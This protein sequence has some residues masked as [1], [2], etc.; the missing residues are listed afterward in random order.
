MKSSFLL[1]LFVLFVNYSFGQQNTSYHPLDTNNP[2]NFN[3]TSIEYNGQKI[4]LGPKT[5]FIDGQLSDEEAG[6]Y[7][8]VFNSIQSASE[9]LTDGTE[10]E[11]MILYI[12]P[13]VYWIDNPDDP[14]VRT[15]Q[16]GPVPY[17]MEIDCEWLRFYGLTTNPENV[18][19]ACNRGQTMGSMGNFTMFHFSGDGTSSENL[20]F[21]N[22]CNVDLKFPLKPELN[23]KKRGD[24][25]VQAQLIHCNGDKIVA[26]N[27][28]F[29]SRLN[30][31][32]FVG[33]KRILF[34]QCHLECTDDALCG[35]G[36]YLN[37]TFD[38]YSS[39]PFY[40]TVGTGSVFLNCDIHTFTHGEQYLTKAN[41]QM[42]IIDSRFNGDKTEYIGWRNIPPVD[43]KNYQYNVSLNNKPVFISSHDSAS[44]IDLTHLPLLN[45]YRLDIG[46]SVVYNTYNL[47]KGNDDWD[48]CDIK[49]IVVEAEK[50][51][52]A[53]YSNIPTQLQIVTS[54]KTVETGKDSVTLFTDIFR[55]GDF[56]TED[57]D[58][59]WHVS[60]DQQ[61][62]LKLI[63]SS[64]THSCKLIPTNQNDET[65]NVI[66]YA[67]TE[68]GLE[69]ACPIHV[70]PAILPA[71]AFTDLPILSKP[72]KNSV[73]VSYKLD[74]PY[75]D[76]SLI[77]WYRC[78]DESGKNPIPVAVSR[79]NTP[80]KEY[81][82]SSRD[83]G[84]Y[85]MVSV[86]PK[87]LR[88]EPGEPQT[89]VLQKA[90]TKNDI[91]N[92][93]KTLTTDFKNTAVQN[94]VEIIPG[95][96]TFKP[97]ET[98]KDG[99]TIVADNNKDAWFYGEGKEGNANMQG[100]LQ[101]GRSA[102]LLY[103]P[104][105]P[106]H[107]KM[108]L[109]MTVSPFKTAG[110]GFSVAPLYMDV[111]FKL[112]TKNMTG[113]GLRFIRTTK[114]GNAVDCYFVKYTNGIASQIGKEITTSCF[115]SPVKITLE[116][117]KKKIKAR[118]STTKDYPS[119][120][121]YPDIMPSVDLQIKVEEND[122]GGFGVQY[123]GGSTTMIND[124]KVEWE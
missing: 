57:I 41:G 99:E 122:F 12:A 87:H 55:F 96:W 13:W 76:Q 38:F 66:I 39:K 95:F 69:A 35:T 50:K 53:N 37:C 16:N 80:L 54:H 40:N 24:A 105:S 106:K 22:Y 116:Y 74:M 26:R 62:L 114:Y 93:P 51:D 6:K 63:P 61:D 8:F 23:R 112:D 52:E 19:L 92:D 25:I 59:S 121:K 100:L 28:N 91:I 115:R 103:T 7:K 56:K 18:V 20:T 124:V 104:V 60:T 123:N 109:E 48:P 85:L 4:N 79:F 58:I 9:Q 15:K 34:D 83:V 44:T 98:E 71:P 30:L 94:Q 78:E 72:N 84:F 32:N 107:N 97:L 11:P 10:S 102:T 113:Y 21:G 27:T 118:A 119:Y 5:F 49:N 65:K 108:K 36:V 46:D 89:Y 110:Q 42:A 1:I 17:G 90:I 31:C 29:I 117:A 88:C 101:T 70:S 75:D 120:K 111:L 3:G 68:D 33:A 43:M 86:K 81:K 82:L 73:L 45:A 67:S 47:L 2:I 14:E 77:T 64:S